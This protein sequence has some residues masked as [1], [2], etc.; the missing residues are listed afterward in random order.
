VRGEGGAEIGVKAEQ[1]NTYLHTFTHIYTSLNTDAVYL[2]E[3]EQ[4]QGVSGGRGV[5]HDCG[6]VHLLH[7]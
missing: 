6:V 1:K 3:G 7:L 5:E 2:G 4:A